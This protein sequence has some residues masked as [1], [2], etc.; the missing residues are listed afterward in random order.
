MIDTVVRWPL[1][2]S[3][4]LIW[5]GRTGNLVVGVIKLRVELYDTEM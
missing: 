1:Q 4:Y 5:M 2:F 3:D